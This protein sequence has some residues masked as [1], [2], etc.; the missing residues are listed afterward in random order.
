MYITELSGG[1][2]KFA[3]VGLACMSHLLHSAPI[4]AIVKLIR[5][6]LGGTVRRIE[7]PFMMFHDGIRRFIDVRGCNIVLSHQIHYKTGK[8]LLNSQMCWQ[9]SFKKMADG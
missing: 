4:K 5:K 1:S 8:C 3:L 9:N 7:P 6:S 2:T